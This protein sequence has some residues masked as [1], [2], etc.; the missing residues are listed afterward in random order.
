MAGPADVQGYAASLWRFVGGPVLRSLILIAIVIYIYG[1]EGLR[2]ALADHLPSLST[3]TDPELKEF[4]EMYGLGA[5]MPFVS[6]VLFATVVHV[7]NALIF[8]VSN[9]LPPRFYTRED[10]AAIRLVHEFTLKELAARLQGTRSAFDLHLAV[11]DRLASLEADRPG[12]PDLGHLGSLAEREGSANAW[13]ASLRFFGFASILTLLVTPLSG[14]E[15]EGAVGRFLQVFVVLVI[16]FTLSAWLFLHYHA[17]RL[18]YGFETV[19]RTVQLQPAGEVP[20]WVLEQ[21]GGKRRR[22]RWWGFAGGELIRSHLASRQLSKLRRRVPI[23]EGQD[24]GS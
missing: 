23:A 2:S 6:I 16:G 14:H 5:V 19:L 11:A 4:M 7:V 21:R 15:T 1:A 17:A 8:A 20:G 9:F 24:V 18:K 3:L 22:E 10:V 13:M 12:H